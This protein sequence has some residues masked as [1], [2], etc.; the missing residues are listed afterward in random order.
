MSSTSAASA[1][2]SVVGERE[3]AASGAGR[4]AGVEVR[5]E[6]FDG[7]ADR[8][9]L[10]VPV[11]HQ[12]VDAGVAL[13]RPGRP[14]GDAAG[15]VAVVAGGGEVLGDLVGALREQLAHL[16]G[17]AGDPPVPQVAR[18]GRR[19]ARS[20]SQLDRPRRGVE[21]ADHRRRLDRVPQRGASRGP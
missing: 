8:V 4:R 18:T 21:P 9:E 19:P 11:R 14:G 17:D 7:P 15:P 16:V 1:S 20:R 6:A 3:R 10:G 12:L 2:I 13:R 5:G